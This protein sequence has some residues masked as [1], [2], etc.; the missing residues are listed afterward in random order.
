MS[1]GG[2]A[3]AVAAA[4]AAVAEAV[5]PVVAV[6]VATDKGGAIV[7]LARLGEKVEERAGGGAKRMMGTRA[8]GTW[9]R[10]AR[11]SDGQP[12]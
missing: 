3:A 11:G 8:K 12:Q 7:F 1:R 2:R 6:A 5:P 9:W 4:A 10:Q